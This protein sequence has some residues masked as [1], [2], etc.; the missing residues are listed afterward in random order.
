MNSKSLF[1]SITMT[2]TLMENKYTKQLYD[3]AIPTITN[4]Q[5]NDVL[6][7]VSGVIIALVL[8][9][10][11]INIEY[12]M[13]TL[14]I[15]LYFYAIKQIINYHVNK[16]LNVSI[17]LDIVYLMI[18][19]TGLMLIHHLLHFVFWFFNIPFFGYILNFVILA[20]VIRLIMQVNRYMESKP[21][22]DLSFVT[23]TNETS[24]PILITYVNFATKFY[25]LN[26]YIESVIN[27]CTKCIV[28]VSGWMESS[29]FFTYKVLESTYAKLFEIVSN[30]KKQKNES[31]QLVETKMNDA[32]SGKKSL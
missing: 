32:D 13:Y 1:I 31:I 4:I 27:Y 16:T 10:N 24:A 6:K 15:G 20:F 25:L 23:E 2:N 28:A 17:L 29:W 9:L 18:S 8:C 7:N 11:I 30:M 21:K 26:I 5:T 12:V 22:T 19:G 14:N 3:F